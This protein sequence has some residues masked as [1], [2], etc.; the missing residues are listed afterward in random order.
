[1]TFF[2][3]NI[4][5]FSSHHLPKTFDLMFGYS[6]YQPFVAPG[7]QGNVCNVVRDFIVAMTDLFSAA[8]VDQQPIQFVF[9]STAILP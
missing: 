4:A 8:M 7:F 9:I 3:F 6:M 1:M 5:C 2:G